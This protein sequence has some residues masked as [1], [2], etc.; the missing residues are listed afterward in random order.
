MVY[1]SVSHW[2]QQVSHLLGYPPPDTPNSPKMMTKNGGYSLKRQ[3]FEQCERLM[4]APR[5]KKRLRPSSQDKRLHREHVAWVREVRALALANR[6]AAATC[7]QRIWRGFRARMRT[8]IRT[9][10][11]AR[12]SAARLKSARIRNICLHMV[13]GMSSDR[14][15]GMALSC[16]IRDLGYGTFLCRAN[17]MALR[18]QTWWRIRRLTSCRFLRRLMWVCSRRKLRRQRA[19]PDVPSGMP[20]GTP[21][22]MPLS[23][24]LMFRDPSESELPGVRLLSR[25][26]ES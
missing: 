12:E 5:P 1:L 26:L 25:M 17:E 20:S 13:Y 19:L 11:S 2:Y 7:V 21:S 14:A 6:V 4:R 18:I 3:V 10:E 23:L 22:G 24:S 16:G 9:R 8:R 15:R